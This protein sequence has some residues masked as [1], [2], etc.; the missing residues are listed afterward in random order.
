MKA[1][2]L[3]GSVGGSVVMTVFSYVIDRESEIPL[4]NLLEGK[5]SG[6]SG[7]L[8]H[9]GAGF[10]FTSLYHVIWQNTRLKPTPVTGLAFGAVN[11]VMSTILWRF[12]SD[13]RDIQKKHYRN[14]FLTHL[15][16]GRSAA[17]C[18]RIGER[19]TAHK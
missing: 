5:V 16:F 12:I 1:N 15:M 2:V 8:I 11:G 18:Y 3:A 9:L 7:W 13:A 17:I 10:L 4:Y 6:K 14:L 19:L